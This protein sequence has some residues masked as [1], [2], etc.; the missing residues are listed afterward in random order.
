MRTH[1]NLPASFTQRE[2][3]LILSPKYPRVTHV[4]GGV[5][6]GGQELSKCQGITASTTVER[7]PFCAP[8]F[9][10]NQICTLFR[11]RDPSD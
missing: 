3:R 2:D 8:A 1:A 6:D 7:R 5:N 10:A 11:R 4:A 9:Q